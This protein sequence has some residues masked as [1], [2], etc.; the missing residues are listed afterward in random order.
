MF[1]D[2]KEESTCT[3]HGSS[4]AIADEV[5]LAKGYR[6]SVSVRIGSQISLGRRSQGTNPNTLTS[7]LDFDACQEESTDRMNF[8][9]SREEIAIM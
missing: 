7:A 4:L 6:N 1:L 5:V 9:E 2:T 8:V 3:I